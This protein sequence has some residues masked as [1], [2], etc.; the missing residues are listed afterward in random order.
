MNPASVNSGIA[1]SVGE[2]LSEYVSMSTVAGV[3]PSLMNSSTAAPP[4]IAKIGAPT[5]A[6]SMTTT[7]PGQ[8]GRC[9]S[10]PGNRT[11]TR[12][13][14]IPAPP[15]ALPHH[16]ASA[17]QAS[18]N[19]I[20]ANPTGRASC[21]TH[22]GTL[23]AMIV[24]VSRSRDDE[25]DGAAGEDRRHA[26]RHRRGEHRGGPAR[27]PG[28]GRAGREREKLALARGDRR[29]EEADPQGEVLNERTGAGDADAEQPAHDDFEQRQRDHRGERQGG[30]PVL[31]RREQPDHFAVPVRCCLR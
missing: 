19:A 21:P 14:T 1:G 5:T 31:D 10:T 2:T 16:D 8:Y 13:I 29:A 26:G 6:A 18:R 28:H 30:D 22:A 27:P 17:R 9:S 11:S 20:R 25:L 12:P 15:I 7:R 4:R 3:T 23:A 24:P